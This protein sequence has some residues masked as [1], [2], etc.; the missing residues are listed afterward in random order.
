MSGLPAQI[1]LMG[2]EAGFAAVLI[3]ALFR[4]RQV[5]GLAPVYTSVGVFYYL[6]TLLAGTTFI[7][8]TPELLLS[9][10]S[11]AHFPASLFAVLL[12][13][14]REDAKEARNMIYGLLIANVSASLLGV[15]VSQHLTGPLSF[16]PLALSPA[17]FVQSPRLFVVGTVVLFAD[18]ILI[19]LVYEAVSRVLRPLFLRIWISLAL[20]LAIDTLL[21]VTGAFVENPAY[22]AILV[23]GMAGKLAA[24]LIYATALAFYLPRAWSSE[25]QVED[26]VRPGLG[27][28]FQ[29]LTYRQRYEALRAQ[30]VRDP[31]TGVHNR[32]FFDEM[33]A[34]QV[35]QSRRG[36]APVTVMLADIDHFKRIN[37]AYGHP[38][39][40]RALKV[41]ADALAGAVRGSDVVC[42]YGG[43]EFCIV[44]PATSIDAAVPLAARVREA[45]PAACARAGVS[46]G[47]RVTVTIG[48]ASCPQDGSDA[49]A[50]MR[51]A[52]RRL[53]RGKEAGRDRVVAAA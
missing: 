28:L 10:G 49:D 20:V 15:L 26:P 7:K 53:Y 45:V 22:R 52:D 19:I 33:L 12:V 14:I 21:F 37:D 46:P 35:A 32:G 31:L 1:A 40:D 11:V 50:V 16:N 42:R 9:P 24:S 48:V 36:G 2:V 47:S 4:L 27:A 44:L 43:E 6:A 3:L 17:V 23:S 29:V 41:I 5:L 13:Y 8:V 18:T 39:G 51:A 25:R 30:A 34:V 38:E